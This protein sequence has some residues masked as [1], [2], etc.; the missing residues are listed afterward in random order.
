MGSLRV[1]PIR[2]PAMGLSL[3]GPSGV[4]VGLPAP[5]WFACFTDAS[6]F[7][8]RPSFDGGLG[9]C[10]GAFSCGRRHR[11]FLVGGYHACVL[12]VCVCACFSWPSPAGRPPGRVLVRLT[13]F[14]GRSWCSLCLL[15]PL[16]AWVALLVV[17]PAFSFPFVRPPCLWCSVFSD[18]ECV[19]PWPHVVPRPF[20]FSFF[21]SLPLCVL[22]FPDCFFCFLPV[23][24]VLFFFFLSSLFLSFLLFCF[25]VP[26]CAGCVVLGWCVRGCG[27]CWCVLLWALC[28]DGGLCALALCRL[29][30]PACPSAFCVVAYCVARARGR[31]AG[32]VAFPRAAVWCCPPPTPRVLCAVFLL[33]VWCVLVVA[34]PPPPAGCGALCCALSCVVSCGPAVCGVFCVVPGVVWRACVGL[35]SCAVLIGA[36]L[37]CILLCCFWCALLSCAAAFSAGCFLGCSLPFCGAPGCVCLCAL[38]V[39][40]CAGVPA[41]L[42]SVRCSLAPAALAGVLCCCLLC[43]RLCCWAW[44]SSGVFWWVLVAPRVVLRWCAVVCLWVLCCAVLLRVVP[45][46]VMLFCAVLFCLPL[47]GAVTRCVV[48]SGAVRCPGVLCLPALCFVLSPR[49]VFVLLWCVA[50][51]CCSPLCFV[52]CTSW[53]VV[54]CVPCPLHPMRCCC[55]ALLSLGALLPCAVPRGAVLLCGAVLS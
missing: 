8:Y 1:V 51:S 30:L 18:P 20:C 12:C 4:G 24:W 46:G 28:F 50:L 17:V 27:V 48:S 5:R 11:S 7:P 37:R 16:Q 9:R 49:A 32:G 39:R 43:L 3:A 34:A 52:P 33:L 47:F 26:C 38:L 22:F 45:T 10:P 15:G 29:L 21:L 55:A 41:S 54:L 40:C 44:L 25:A 23:V 42:L 2:G 19:G 53:G 14:C 13:F 31:C 35:D 36:V 6:G